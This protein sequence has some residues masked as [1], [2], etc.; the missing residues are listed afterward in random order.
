MSGLVGIGDL[1]LPLRGL[2]RNLLDVEVDNGL[3]RWREWNFDNRRD[4]LVRRHYEEDQFFTEFRHD[5]P[6]FL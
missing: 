6:S 1:G 4:Q 2:G 5:P 3:F